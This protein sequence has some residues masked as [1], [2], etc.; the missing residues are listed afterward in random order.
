MHLSDKKWMKKLVGNQNNLF[1]ALKL[2][3]VEKQGI[4]YLVVVLLIQRT[5]LEWDLTIG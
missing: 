1:V 4:G 2:Y 5:E 3:F